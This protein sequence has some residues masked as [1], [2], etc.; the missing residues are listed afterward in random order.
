MKVLTI[1]F[2]FICCSCPLAI[3]QIFPSRSI[4]LAPPVRP[5]ADTSEGVKYLHR[6][7]IWGNLGHG[8]NSTGDRFGWS[9][10]FGGIIQFVEWEHSAI[11]MTGDIEVLADTHNDIS[12][13]PRDVFWTEGFL[14]TDR[15]GTTELS[16]GY[17]H[18]CHHNI[19]NL[20]TDVV[21]SNE[22]RTLIYGSA[23]VRSVWKNISILGITSDLW[24]ELD[25]Y[26][27][28][29]DDRHP[30]TDTMTGNLNDMSTSLSAGFKFLIVK[31]L[32]IRA[33]AI[34]SAFN[35]YNRI[36][37]NSR[38]ELGA[39]FSGAAA[40]MNIFLGHE[41][42]ADDLNRPVPVHSSYW[43]LGFRFIGKDS[44]L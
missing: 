8:F 12:F 10:S 9:I 35:G 16:A 24:S 17:I 21:G 34:A 6:Q 40:A 5:A 37:V 3:G 25:Y 2:L 28:K 19:D 41:S 1:I 31:P 39:E 13:N 18:R 20:E 32:Y 14:Y 7:G 42:L 29:E 43:Y 27:I 36:A 4:I 26:L 33:S 11:S 38:A 15:I 23:I 30:T 22:A 44:G